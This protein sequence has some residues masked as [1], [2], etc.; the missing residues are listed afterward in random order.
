MFRV[1]MHVMAQ[2]YAPDAR[3]IDHAWLELTD[4]E[5]SVQDVKPIDT[6]EYK[7]NMARY[8]TKPPHEALFG[9]AQ[10]LAELQDL[11]NR[12]RL[13]LRDYFG[14]MRKAT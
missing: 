10:A 14:S 11:S 12:R 9:N 13:R 2:G 7:R 8:A 6:D 4:G 5:G 1:H 3:E